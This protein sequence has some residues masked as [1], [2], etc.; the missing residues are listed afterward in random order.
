MDFE[1]YIS[2]LKSERNFSNYT[3]I[4]YKI[5]LE[6]FLEYLKS[7]NIQIE[8]VDRI[9]AREFLYYL[10]TRNFHRRSLARKISAVRS[11]YK[12]LIREGQL[13]GNPF[14]LVSTPKLQKRLPN[15]LYKE[16]TEKLLEAANKNT[17]LGLRDKAMLEL[18]YG[19]GIRVS[20]AVKL[21]IPDIDFEGGEVRVFGKGSKERIV[22]IG[23]FAISAGKEYLLKRG[24]IGTKAIFVNKRGGRLTARSVERMIKEYSKKAGISKPI[25]PHT[26]RHTFATDLLSNGADLRTVQELLGHASLS[27]TQVY[28]HITKEKL[29]SVYDLAHPRAKIL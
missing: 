28:T 29:K 18:L 5:D 8:A 14:N 23:K 4:N 22:L 13:K 3:I 27:T 24:K 12:W 16:E 20:E 25:T 1:K 9:A 10:E 7:K 15:F 19:S 17:V 11:F 21:N 26:L 2:S 6:Q